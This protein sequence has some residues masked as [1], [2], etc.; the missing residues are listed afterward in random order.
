[1]LLIDFISALY[2]QLNYIIK[3]S[4]RLVKLFIGA[5]KS[6]DS[7]LHD[8]IVFYVNTESFAIFMFSEGA[9]ITTPFQQHSAQKLFAGCGLYCS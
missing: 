5:F 3:Y 9:D 7:K 2:L 4:S 6:T 1:M 8:V